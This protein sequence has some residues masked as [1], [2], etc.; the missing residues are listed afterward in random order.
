MVQRPPGASSPIL[1]RL[2]QVVDLYGRAAF[3]VRDGPGQ[4]QDAVV[5]AGGQVKPLQ[6]LPYECPARGAE[7]AYFRQHP[8]TDLGI[9]VHPLHVP[10]T[11]RLQGACLFHPQAYGLRAFCQW[12]GSRPRDEVFDFYRLYRQVNINPVHQGPRDSVLIALH[13]VGRAN[14]LPGRVSPVPAGTGIHG[15]HQHKPRRVV[16][17]IP[18]PGKP[19]CSV[20]QGLPQHLQGGRRE[21]GQ[22]VQVE[23]PVVGQ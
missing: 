2:C 15:G 9:G 23:H 12:C 7:P 5:G 10:E 4:A 21:F 3:Q 18:R 6:G 20:F 8:H 16:H 11:F 13:L 17:L 22:F 19:Y 14:T 1:Y